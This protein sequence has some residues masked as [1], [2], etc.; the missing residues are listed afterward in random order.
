MKAMFGVVSMLVALA[1]V[2]LLMVKQLR[3]VGHAEPVDATAAAV[4]VPALSGSGALRDQ[5]M[6]LENKVAA[7]A[8]KAMAQ[9]EHNRDQAIDKAQGQ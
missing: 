7:D 3:A 5:A 9:G 8:A 4:A 1:V 6:Q 2:G